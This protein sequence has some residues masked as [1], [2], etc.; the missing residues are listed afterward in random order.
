MH[1]T[2]E[3]NTVS[4]HTT[5]KKWNYLNQLALFENGKA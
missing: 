2:N 4:T 1:F 5:R 3:Q